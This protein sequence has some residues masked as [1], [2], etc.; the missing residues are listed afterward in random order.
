MI[1][2]DASAYTKYSAERGWD[3][4]KDGWGG[5]GSGPSGGGGGGGGRGRVSGMSDL[6]AADHGKFRGPFTPHLR[7]PYLNAAEEQLHLQC[8]CSCRSMLL[9]GFGL[10]SKTFHLFV[11][12]VT[13]SGSWKLRAAHFIVIAKIDGRA[14]AA[15]G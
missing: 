11:Y 8:V 4:K 10:L 12:P 3:N 14:D 6:V 1:G 5:G 2:K 15:I 13:A 7:C 9:R